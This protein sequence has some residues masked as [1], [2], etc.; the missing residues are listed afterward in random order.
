[1]GDIPFTVK[2]IRAVKKEALKAKLEV[3]ED[4]LRHSR[5]QRTRRRVR[6]V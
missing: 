1:M 5:L 2:R 3:G 6:Q 4:C